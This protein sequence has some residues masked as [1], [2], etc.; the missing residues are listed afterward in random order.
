MAGRERREADMAELRTTVARVRAETAAF[1]ERMERAR[2][3][4]A[5]RVE[6]ARADREVAMEELRHE[7]RNGQVPA[8]DRALVQRVLDGETTW[9]AVYSG[10]D[11]HWTAVQHRERFGAELTAGVERLVEDDPDVASWLAEVRL[12]TGRGEADDE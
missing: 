3:E 9:R 7:F 5:P 11:D 8:E 4:L 12:K 1:R 6:R 2:A 10:E